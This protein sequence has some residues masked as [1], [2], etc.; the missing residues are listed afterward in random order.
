MSSNSS[1]KN[2]YIRVSN[3]FDVKCAA[4]LLNSDLKEEELELHSTAQRF[5]W[6]MDDGEI[7]SG[8]YSEMGNTTILIQ[9]M[10]QEISFLHYLH[11]CSKQLQDSGAENV[12]HNLEMNLLIFC[13]KW[14]YVE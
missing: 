2:Q 8:N 5:N 14:S 10:C 9:K 3:L 4:S 13:L 11:R 7:T 12:F 6:P 1:S